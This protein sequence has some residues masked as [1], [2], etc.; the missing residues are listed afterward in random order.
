M[1]TM[2]ASSAMTIPAQ[3]IVTVGDDHRA[4]R[5]TDVHDGAEGC[6]AKAASYTLTASAERWVDCPANLS[7]RM[8]IT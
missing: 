8:V 7:A 6:G 2:T 5:M 4:A 1:M 3:V